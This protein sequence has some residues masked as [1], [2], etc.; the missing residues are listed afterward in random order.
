[1][2]DINKQVMYEPFWQMIRVSLLGSWNDPNKVRQNLMLLGKYCNDDRTTLNHTHRVIN[3]LA[4][5]RMGYSGQKLTGSLQ[6]RLV[7][8]KL[9]YLRELEFNLKNVFKRELVA[10]TDAEV[11]FRWDMVP[12]EKRKAII[13]DLSKRQKLHKDSR[14]REDLA[15]FLNLVQKLEND[16][17]V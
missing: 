11:I 17:N 4:A 2:Q 14:Y 5:V 8:K 16:G 15:H 1:M 7:Q 10:V 12:E 9:L 6:D 3:L 13:Q